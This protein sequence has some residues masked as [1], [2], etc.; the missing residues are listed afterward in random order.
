MNSIREIVLDAQNRVHSTSLLPDEAVELLK[1]LSSVYGNV[2]DEIQTKELAYNHIL[3]AELD[4]EKTASKAKIKAEVSPE[5]QDFLKA[6]NTEKLL[7]K[8]LSSLKTFIR[9]KEQ[10]YREGKNL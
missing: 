9:S 3:L 5:Y 7:I 6:K 8:L 1:T 4:K 2:L 10:E